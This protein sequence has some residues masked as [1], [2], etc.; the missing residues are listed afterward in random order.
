MKAEDYD[1]IRKTG[2]ALVECTTAVAVIEWLAENHCLKAEADPR[3]IDQLAHDF[4]LRFDN[5]AIRGDRGEKT[6]TITKEYR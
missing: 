2:V 5:I 1:R 3:Y 4:A 6:I